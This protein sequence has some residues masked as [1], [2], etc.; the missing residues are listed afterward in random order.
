MRPASHR[1]LSSSPPLHM[2]S[3]SSARRSSDTEGSSSLAMSFGQDLQS[4]RKLSSKS[5][6]SVLGS[7]MHLFFSFFPDGGIA[8]PAPEYTTRYLIHSQDLQ[9]SYAVGGHTPTCPHV[10]DHGQ[11]VSR[12][13]PMTSNQSLKLHTEFGSCN[14]ANG[15]SDSPGSRTVL[16]IPLK[17]ELAAQLSVSTP[18]TR[19]LIRAE[20]HHNT[21]CHQL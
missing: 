1:C 14:E 10:H 20:P 19:P 4:V 2:I 11:S 3:Q 12:K 9:Q 8:T 17:R 13:E 5:M 15:C 7:S 18:P 6:D 21:L 16:W